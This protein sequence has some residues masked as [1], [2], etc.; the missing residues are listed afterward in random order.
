MVR[1]DAARSQNLQKALPLL[2]V[3]AELKKTHKG[4][5]HD[6]EEN[7]SGDVVKI[8]EKVLQTMTTEWY[9]TR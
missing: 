1:I 8:T 7:V 9:C 6:P 3:V 2:S 4:R 5:L